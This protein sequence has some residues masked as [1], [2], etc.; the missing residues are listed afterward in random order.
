MFKSLTPTIQSIH[1]KLVVEFVSV[2]DELAGR[3]S[4]TGDMGTW[5]SQGVIFLASLK[6]TK[7][8]KHKMVGF[9]AIP[10]ET[11]PTLWLAITVP[12]CFHHFSMQVGVWLLSQCFFKQWERP[13]F[14]LSLPLKCTL[15]NKL[16]KAQKFGSCLLSHENKFL[17]IKSCK[18]IHTLWPAG[19]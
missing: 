14:Y 3:Y 6:K 11:T 2:W 19:W 7:K 5:S 17:A 4:Q 18:R 10:L 1:Q 16:S 12:V 13:G 9:R 8:K 15:M